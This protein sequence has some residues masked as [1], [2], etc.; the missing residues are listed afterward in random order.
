MSISDNVLGVRLA[1]VTTLETVA[2]HLIVLDSKMV[3]GR[4]W[5]AMESTVAAPPYT[6]TSGSED[7]SQGGDDYT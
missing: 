5:S 1:H 4:H 3:D 6:A 2:P 7:T